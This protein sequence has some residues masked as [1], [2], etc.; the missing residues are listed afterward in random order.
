MNIFINK[1]NENYFYF[2]MQL[3]FMLIYIYII[4]NIFDIYP[5]FFKN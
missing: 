3:N 4:F 2:Y 5:N 1:K